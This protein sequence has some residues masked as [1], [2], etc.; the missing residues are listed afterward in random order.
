MW[1]LFRLFIFI[2]VLGANI[3]GLRLIDR[4]D[5]IVYFDEDLYILA[6]EKQQQVNRRMRSAHDAKPAVRW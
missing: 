1:F 6:I 4:H 3:S 5:S 2:Y